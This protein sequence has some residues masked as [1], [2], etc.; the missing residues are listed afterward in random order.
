ML[1]FANY[2]KH[3]EFDEERKCWICSIYYDKADETELLIDI[4][5]SV[6]WCG[7]WIRSRFWDLLR[8]ESGGSTGYFSRY[9]QTTVHT[10]VS[11]RYFHAHSARKHLAEHGGNSSFAVSMHR[12]ACYSLQDHLLRGYELQHG[13][14]GMSRI[15]LSSAVFVYTG[16]ARRKKKEKRSRPRAGYGLRRRMKRCA[17]AKVLWFQGLTNL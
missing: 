14:D 12:G 8:P 16:K 4:C 15:L 2:E 9:E 13:Q 1:Q 7:C 11:A 17:S 6:R 5:P 3:T 10:V